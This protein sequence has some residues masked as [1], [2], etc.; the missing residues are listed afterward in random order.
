M[1]PWPGSITP[2]GMSGQPPVPDELW[3]KIPTDAQ[4]AILAL[5]SSLERRI[6]ALEARLNRN[7][8]NSSKPPSTEPLHL[9]RQ[10]PRPTS[11]KRR[12][13]QAGH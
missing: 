7:S 5:V 1:R 13:G 11:K 6:A 8:S 9:K 4:S 2:D 10:P 12:G 3:V